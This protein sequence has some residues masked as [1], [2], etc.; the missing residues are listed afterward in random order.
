MSNKWVLAEYF[1]SAKKAVDTILYISKYHKSISP[2]ILKKRSDEAQRI[3][4]ISCAIVIDKALSKKTRNSIRSENQIIQ[5]IYYERDK[6]YA[7]ADNDYQKSEFSSFAELAEILKTR[8]GEVYFV[9]Q[10]ALPSCFASPDYVIFDSEL[11]RIVNQIDYRRE[12]EI[13]D[14]KYPGRKLTMSNLAQNAHIIKALNYSEDI[15]SIPENKR[16]EYGIVLKMGLTLE[17]SVQSLQDSFVLI[18]IYFDKDVWVSIKKGIDKLYQTAREKG[19]MNECDLLKPGVSWEA[20]DK[21]YKQ[22]DTNHEIVNT[23]TKVRK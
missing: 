10:D 2:Y 3:F 5:A 14:I 9:C 11:F 7:H 19:L 22:L 23:K 8:L 1:L 12:Q 13:L 17:E 20:I 15:K 4:Y 21:L 16:N 6:K 18:N